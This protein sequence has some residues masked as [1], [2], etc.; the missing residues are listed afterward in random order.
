MRK[1]RDF[2]VLG[3]GGQFQSFNLRVQLV[4][5]LVGG[6]CLGA[7]STDFLQRV[8]SSSSRD[9]EMQGWGTSLSLSMIS[10]VAGDFG[11]GGKGTWFRKGER[12]D[13][14]LC[15][16]AETSCALKR[17]APLLPQFLNSL[18]LLVTRGKTA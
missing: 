14:R 15:E 10:L 1:R 9:R 18:R 16:P 8:S 11:G 2:L 13:A 17:S 6:V 7:K 12:I 5:F 3:S 4:D